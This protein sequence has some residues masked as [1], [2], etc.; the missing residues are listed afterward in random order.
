MVKYVAMFKRPPNMT[1]EQ[2]RKWWLGPHATI[3]K[4][5]P[6][7]RKYAIN[8]VVSTPSDEPEYDGFSEIIFD[9]LDD[10]RRALASSAM[11]EARKDVEEQGLTVVSR[12][13]AEE[14]V[15]M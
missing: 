9:S 2:L 3:S 1:V 11:A 6:G 5:L 14:H 15:I 4:R 12:I 7:L 10:L 13:T 8:F